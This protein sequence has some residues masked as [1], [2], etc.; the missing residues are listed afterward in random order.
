MPPKDRAMSVLVGRAHRG[1]ARVCVC[2][3]RLGPVCV[4]F[5][6]VAR[7]VRR[8]VAAWLWKVENTSWDGLY[9]FVSMTALCSHYICSFFFS[10]SCGRV[11][12]RFLLFDLSMHC[13]SRFCLRKIFFSVTYG[14][15]V[16]PFHVRL[17]CKYP[18]S[19]FFFSQLEHI[20]IFIITL[21]S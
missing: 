5:G 8:T 4:E 13:N 15:Y 9:C 11:R 17:Q 21:F 3:N 6:T 12:V 2:V 20:V 10:F 18:P 14:E 1:A 19:L 7:F 16:L